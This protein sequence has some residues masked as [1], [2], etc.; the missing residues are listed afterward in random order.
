[1]STLPDQYPAILEEL[2]KQIRQARL[3]ASLAANAEMLTLY[4]Q[5]G[6]TILEQ[7]QQAGWGAKVI[8]NLSAD[9]RKEFPDMQGISPRNLKQ[10]YERIWGKQVNGCQQG[11]WVEGENKK[12]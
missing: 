3:K 9:L 4:W 11:Q 5:I 6:K 1:M 7:Q 2:K 12:G 10:W 8:D